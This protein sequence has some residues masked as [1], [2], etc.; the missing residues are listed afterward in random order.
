MPPIR[1]IA[2]EQILQIAEKPYPLLRFHPATDALPGG[3]SVAMVPAIVDWER[4]RLDGGD[5]DYY[6]VRHVNFGSNPAGGYGM[7]VTVKIPRKG[8]VR[9]EWVST[10]LRVF[11]KDTPGGHG[12]LRLIFDPKRRPIVLNEDGTPFSS[13]PYLD[14]LM[15]SFEAWRPPAAHFDP[16]AGL[17]PTAYALTMR[18]YAATQRFLEDSLRGLSWHCYPLKLPPVEEAHDELLYTCLTMGDSLA[19]HTLHQHLHSLSPHF[20]GDPRDY[21]QPTSEQVEKLREILDD[22]SVPDDPIAQ[23]M[24]G[25]TSYHLLLRSCI[26]MGLTAIDASVSRIHE[27]HPELGAYHPLKVTPGEIPSWASSLAHSNR[28]NMLMRL[29]S[30]LYWLVHNQNVLPDRAHQIL[31]EAGLLELDD[32]DRPVK[33]VYYISEDT[34]YGRLLDNLMQ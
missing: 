23:I 12:Q 8:V 31:L 33:R 4:S 26:T 30:T 24:G 1:T 18:C 27:R 14:D 2:P 29:P 5:D 17:D 6:L 22:A 32:E 15:F 3:L 16:L 9:A 20:D 7:L 10:L 13:D 34:P 11:R 28:R 21:P 19:R 25:D